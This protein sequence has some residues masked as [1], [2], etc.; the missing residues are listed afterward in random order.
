MEFC[1]ARMRQ[2]GT[3]ACCDSHCLRSRSADLHLLC[4]ILRDTCT[5]NVGRVVYVKKDI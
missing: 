3:R 5:W 4:K 1:E 2:D